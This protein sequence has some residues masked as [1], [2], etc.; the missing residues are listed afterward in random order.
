MWLRCIDMVL[1]K[2]YHIGG[3]GIQMF[4]FVHHTS[5]NF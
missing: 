3:G 2:E 1:I 4:S 5:F